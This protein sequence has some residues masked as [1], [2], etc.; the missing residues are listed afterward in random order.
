MNDLKKKPFHL[1][2]TNPAYNIPKFRMFSY[3]PTFLR[4]QLYFRN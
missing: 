2:Q 4:Y 3:V 1:N